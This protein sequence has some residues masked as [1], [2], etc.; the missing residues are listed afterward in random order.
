MSSY[1]W[2][3][4]LFLLNFKLSRDIPFVFVKFWDIPG[5]IGISH[6]NWDVP[7]FAGISQVLLAY[8]MLCKFLQTCHVC[9]VQV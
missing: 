6:Q 7:G 8:P 9:T 1:P 3:S 2:I 4:Y 5:Y